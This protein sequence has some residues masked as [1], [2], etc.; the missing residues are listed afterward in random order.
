M[1][2]INLMVG[3][4]ALNGKKLK[5]PEQKRLRDKAEVKVAEIQDKVFEN[6]LKRAGLGISDR[7][8]SGSLAP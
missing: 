1:R 4:A 5:R 2:Y 8:I 6:L 3:S 7:P